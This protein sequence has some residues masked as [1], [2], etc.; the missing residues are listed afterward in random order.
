MTLHNA[1]QLD[2]NKEESV[3]ENKQIDYSVGTLLKDI[4][5]RF[6]DESIGIIPRL[7]AHKRLYCP[8]YISRTG[9]DCTDEMIRVYNE[10]FYIFVVARWNLRLLLMALEPFSRFQLSAPPMPTIS[11]SPKNIT[12]GEV[13][14]F[15]AWTTSILAKY[16]PVFTNQCLTTNARERLFYHINESL[17]APE[18]RMLWKKQVKYGSA[19][20]PTC[21]AKLLKCRDLTDLIEV[22]SQS[23][24]DTF[25]GFFNPVGRSNL[26]SN[27]LSLIAGFKNVNITERVV[28]NFVSALLELK[29]QE[30]I[31]D[32]S[33]STFSLNPK[34]GS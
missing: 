20:L 23:S 9:N 27:Y 32:K 8:P 10:I 24:K 33:I 2:E 12:V 13:R 31:Q 18:W 3:I 22:A 1:L 11:L 15:N 26:T 19:P 7:N 4:R 14:D 5:Y 21:I 29:M 34:F 30:I 6:T 17:T 16:F 25:I 28:D